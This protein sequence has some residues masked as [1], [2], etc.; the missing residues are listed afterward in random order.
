MSVHPSRTTLR[1]HLCG[2]LRSEHIG[3]SVSLCGW[4]AKRREHGDK[5]AFVDLRDHSGIVQCVIDDGVDLRSEYVARITGTVRARP[6][7]TV[8][9]NLSTGE[10]EIGECTVEILRSADPPPF[11]IDARAD[12]V[13]EN[14]R[15]QYRYLDIRRE[16]MQRNIRVRAKVNSAVRAAMERQGFVEVETPM[17]VP[18]TPEGAR[19]FLVPSRKEPGSFYALPQSPQLFKQ[20]LMVAGIDRYYQIAR[21][22]RDEDLRADRQYEFMQLDAEM[23]FVTQDDVLAAI[24]EAVLSAAEAVTG[25]RPPSIERI[26]WREAMDRYGIDK[27]DLRF[28]MELVELTSI[29]ASTEFKAFAGAASIKGIRAPGRAEEFGRNKLDAL[30]DRA[31][32]MG[33]KGLV[34][35]KVAADGSLDSPV[36]KF[37]STNEQS[38]LVAAVGAEPGDLVLVVADEWMTTCEVLGQLRN[39]LGRPPVHQG[40]YRYVWVVEFPLFVGVD[41]ETGRPKP[42]HHPFCRPHPDDLD[43]F[44][45][46]PLSVRAMAYDLVLNGWELGSGSI[47]IHEPEMQRK[48]FTALGI[49]DEEA[50]RKFGFFLKPFTFGAPPHGGFAFGLDRLV[51]I[52]AGEENIREVIAFPKT[53]SGQDPMTNAPTRAEAK[54]LDELGIRTLPPKV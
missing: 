37:L 13:D 8:N 17:L 3:Q 7:G 45:T 51:A 4:I 46:D 2:E 42:G 21:C 44:E 22:L 14:V 10:I 15:L 26:T 9:A 38:A 6:S 39:D 35:L 52:L 18:S 24:S 25:E 5:L 11:P 36:A 31:K 49:S 12:D 19:E 47:R 33:A 34:W 1:T 54:Q 16:R 48:V 32:K 29:F 53:Q 40:P 23:S 43:K 20:L 50:N 28:G 27:P 41:K 30:T